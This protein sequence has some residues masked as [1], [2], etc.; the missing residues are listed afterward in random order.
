MVPVADTE[1]LA[2]AMIEMASMPS[3]TL[4]RMGTVGRKM[5]LKEFDEQV[6]IGQYLKIIASS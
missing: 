4:Q 3:E 5:A 1:K 2:A 6:I